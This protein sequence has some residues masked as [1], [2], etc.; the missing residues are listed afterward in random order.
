MTYLD[1]LNE[2]LKGVDATLKKKPVFVAPVRQFNFCHYLSN[3]PS[4]DYFEH[5]YLVVPSNPDPTVTN[6]IHGHYKHELCAASF[7]CHEYGWKPEAVHNPRFVALFNQK[8]KVYYEGK[9]I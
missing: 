9:G 2:F 8:W 3:S 5:Y 6:V 1:E 7:F 4:L